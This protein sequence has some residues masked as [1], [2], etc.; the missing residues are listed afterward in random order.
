MKY[1]LLFFIKYLH[2]NCIIFRTL[3]T[4]Q[5]S[6][7]NMLRYREFIHQC[8]VSC[9]KQY[10][11]IYISLPAI[12]SSSKYEFGFPWNFPYWD[13]V[14]FIVQF[15]IAEVYES[16]RTFMVSFVFDLFQFIYINAMHCTFIVKVL[17]TLISSVQSTQ[18]IVSSS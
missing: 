18:R 17:K 9:L 14:Q 12:E 16:V 7:S 5:S 11:I 6:Y 1:Y 4:F 2:L 10:I 3:I 8:G 15:I 13:S